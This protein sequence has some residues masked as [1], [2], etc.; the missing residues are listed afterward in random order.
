MAV[1][2]ISVTSIG[3]EGVVLAIDGTGLVVLLPFVERHA[4][5]LLV[6]GAGEEGG[7]REGEGEEGERKLHFSWLVKECG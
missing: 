4:L 7:G 5:V 1:K 2:V 3:Q 6:L